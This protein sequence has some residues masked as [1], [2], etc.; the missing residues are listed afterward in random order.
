MP[1]VLAHGHVLYLGAS[2]RALTCAATLREGNVQHAPGTW[3][4]PARA[5]L[6]AKAPGSGLAADAIM[7]EARLRL[8]RGGGGGCLSCEIDL[9]MEMKSDWR[10]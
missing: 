1:P 9:S 4:L 7:V 2:A 10:A 8:L 3:S 6:V 5:Y